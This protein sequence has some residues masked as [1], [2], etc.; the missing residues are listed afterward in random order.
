[1]IAADFEKKAYYAP[2]EIARI[3]AVHP[4]TVLDWI[5][6]GRLFAHRLS[7]RVFRI[8]LGSFM[9]FLGAAPRAARRELSDAEADAIWAR[10]TGEHQPSS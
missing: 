7:P 4:S 6:R 10:I 5:H 1:M 3:L 9:Q 2:A 8:P